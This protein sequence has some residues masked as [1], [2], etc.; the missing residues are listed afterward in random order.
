M[1]ILIGEIMFQ[2]KPKEENPRFLIKFREDKRELELQCEDA[3]YFA[4]MI[5][6]AREFL[7]NQRK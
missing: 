1:T 5:E 3:A 4:A 6:F 2:K 7:Q